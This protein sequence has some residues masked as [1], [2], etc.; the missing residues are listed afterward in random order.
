MQML[1]S[2]GHVLQQQ[3]QKGDGGHGLHYHH[4][5][6]NDDGIVPSPDADLPAAAVLK[7]G[8]LGTGNGGSGFEGNSYQK[9]AAVADSAQDPAGMIGGFCAQF[10]NQTNATL[11]AVYAHSAIADELGQ[12]QYVVLPHQISQKLPNF[13]KQ[14]EN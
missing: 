9:I 1:H 7:Q 2:G 3:I 12:Q 8:C 6:G 14:Y 10:N 11:A 13:M 4:G 5:P